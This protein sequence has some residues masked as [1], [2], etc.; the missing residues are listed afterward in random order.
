MLLN[1][2]TILTRFLPSG[3]K[4]RY[5]RERRA[6]HK[7]EKANRIDSLYFIFT[8]ILEPAEITR[9][10]HPRSVRA[11]LT[12]LPI[13]VKV[14]WLTSADSNAGWEHILGAT[15]TIRATSYKMKLREDLRNT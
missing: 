7:L 1:S 13:W 11:A 10:R 6:E 14:G 4:C 9:S 8:S 2:A 5:L 3:R 15:S 12:S